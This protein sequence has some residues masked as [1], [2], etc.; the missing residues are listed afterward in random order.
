MNGSLLLFENGAVFIHWNLNASN[1]LKVKF[2]D[3]ID[4]CSHEQYFMMKYKENHVEKSC[5]VEICEKVQ[6]ADSWSKYLRAIC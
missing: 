4:V 3:L 2:T 6:K 1:V 5:L